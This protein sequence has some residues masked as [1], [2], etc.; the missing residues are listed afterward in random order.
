[1]ANAIHLNFFIVY[2][3][4]SDVRERAIADLSMLLEGNHL[5]HNIAA[6][7]PLAQIAETHDLV[8]RAR[9]NGNVVL[10]VEQGTELRQAINNTNPKEFDFIVISARLAKHIDRLTQRYSPELPLL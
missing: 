10:E 3:L 8:E 1:M 5:I 6:R 7:L 4:D 9:V 2:S